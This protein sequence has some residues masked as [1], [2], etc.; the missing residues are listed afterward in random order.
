MHN[1]LSPVGKNSSNNNYNNFDF[2]II[3]VGV[4]ITLM[5]LILIIRVVYLQ[6]YEFKTYQTRSIENHIQVVPTGA[7]RGRIFDRNGE[8]I[9]GQTTD[10]D[11]I[12]YPDEGQLADEKV[13]SLLENTI[14]LTLR[15]RK[16]IEQSN[17]RTRREGVIIRQKI[18]YEEI[19]KITSLHFL[20]SGLEVG[21]RQY[22]Y[23]PEKSTLATITGYVGKIS[24]SE[25]SKI[26]IA[27]KADE[28]RGIDYIGKVG[29]EKYYEES[30][31]GLPGVK[32]IETTAGGRTVRVLSEQPPTP[33]K[34]L[35]TAIDTNLQRTIL[36]AMGETNGAVVV[37]DVRNGDVLAL[38]SNKSY[39]PNLFV[40]EV[41]KERADLF[42]DANKLLLNR[43]IAG[44]YP[45]A[46]T[47]KPFV[48]IA[49]LENNKRS[50]KDTIFCPGYFS[51]PGSTHR[52]RD[53]N[54]NGHGVV[55]FNKSLVQSVDTYYYGLAVAV[56]VDILSS[57]ISQ[58]RFGKLTAIDLVGESAA[59]MPTS[60]WKK[61]RFKRDWTAGDTVSMGIGQGYM[62]ATPLQIAVGYSAI[63]NRGFAYRPRVVKE[64]RN[65]LTG[66]IDEVPVSKIV[67]IK[68]SDENINAL[69]Q[70]LADVNKFGTA[71]RAFAGA[72]YTSAGKTGTAQVISIAQD[73]TYRAS[74]L[75][76]EYHDHALFA[77]FAPVENPQIAVVAVL[78]NAGGGS[79][80]AA[81][82]VRKVMDEYFGVSN[83]NL[84]VK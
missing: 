60:E 54:K 83:S 25:K 1:R 23:Y 29:L 13:I 2:R 77:G 15:E 84:K 33:G 51:L 45:P 69:I 34:D 47:F 64:I 53:W 76:A 11:L 61:K 37:L 68:I 81:P 39:D 4:G 42:N 17:L 73:K 6:V 8:I 66:V 16:L 10:F 41:G 75:K 3:V 62:L 7:L 24:E 82:L 72:K 56:G 31:R 14:N 19:A 21:T 40:G 58:F 35:I 22:R 49:G 63:A 28:Y 9:A 5:M 70:A 36:T 26:E 57:Y 59:L 78:E 20:Q 80:K 79:A 74:E 55:D 50:L 12:Y 67:D 43:A 27:G 46:S 18:N 65:P 52:Y 32:E 30:L 44:V 71:A 48:G 38:V